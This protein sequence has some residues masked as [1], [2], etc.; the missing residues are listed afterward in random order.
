MMQGR[1]ERRPAA[2]RSSRL[3]VVLV[4]LAVWTG[5]SDERQPADVTTPGAV[6]ASAAGNDIS[7]AMRA[8][9]RAT[10]GLMRRPGV[11]GTG[12]RL[13]ASGPAVVVYLMSAEHRGPA[14]LPSHV[15]GFP[16]EV[17][18]T[19]MIVARDVANPRTKE[20]PAPNGFS[21]GHPTITAG[22]IGARVKDAAG[23]VLILSNNHVLAAS[24]AGG[25]LA[26]GAPA[27]VRRAL[28][29]SWKAPVGVFWRRLTEPVTATV[30]QLLVMWAWH[31]PALFDRTLTSQGW[32]IAQHMSFILAS[33]IF[34]TAMLNSWRGGYLLSAACLFAT[35]LVEGA[36]GALMALSASPW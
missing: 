10:P 13:N 4:A 34:W 33:L 7:E 20:R 29:G 21:V 2:A 16:L 18:I 24:N 26:W 17:Q 1:M 15:E 9:E 32:H 28:G 14:N 19:G 8:Q 3:S 12:V 22:T 5:C 27:P 35:S 30:V 6:S 25:I 36:L 11:V 23:R 31:A